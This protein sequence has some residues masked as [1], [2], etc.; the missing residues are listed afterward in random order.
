[1]IIGRATF[2]DTKDNARTVVLHPEPVEALWGGMQPRP[3][4]VEALARWKQSPIFKKRGR[5][6]A[7]DKSSYRKAWATA[8][9]AA[10][11]GHLEVAG[12]WLRDFRPNFKRS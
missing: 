12:M 5:S 9:K 8:I 4:S 6:K 2:T 10:S 1:M 11:Q 3:G 7:I